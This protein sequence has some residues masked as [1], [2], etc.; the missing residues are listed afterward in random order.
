MLRVIA[1]ISYQRLQPPPVRDG[2]AEESCR[3]WY[4]VK[5]KHHID[6]VKPTRTHHR[7]SSSSSSSSSHHHHLIIIIITTLGY[8]IKLIGP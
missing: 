8:K 6:P 7:S 4:F 5:G 1:T 3:Y 2:G